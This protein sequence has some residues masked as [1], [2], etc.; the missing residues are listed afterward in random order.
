MTAFAIGPGELEVESLGP[1]KF[2]S[3]LPSARQRFVDDNDR[4]LFPSTTAE[5]ETLGSSSFR[6]AGARRNVFFEGSRS[7]CGIV[8]CGGLC[9]GI[10]NVIRAVVLTL[11]HGYG[12]R[13][14]LG[15]RY[16]Y[17]GVAGAV[18]AGPPM[19]LTPAEVEPIHRW[20]GTL[21]GSS[22]GPQDVGRMVDRLLE[23]KIDVLFTIGGDGTL[24]GAAALAAEIA[25][26]GLQIAVIGVP[27][28]IDNDIS[29]IERSFG[30]ATA[31][32]EAAKVVAGAHAEALG[33]LGGIGLVKLM[34][35]HSGFIAAHA[36]LATS[37][38]NFCLVPEVKVKL[39]LFLDALAER[40][41]ER[42]HAVIVVA[43]GAGQELLQ[44]DTPEH[45]A[46]GNLKLEDIGLYLKQAIADGL[47]KRG[48]TFSIKYLDPSYSVRS[49]PANALDAE[50]CLAL[51]QHAAHAGMAGF[52]STMVGF[53]NQH[54][55]LLPIKA[56]V[57]RRKQLDPRG[58]VW[59]RV[60]EATGQSSLR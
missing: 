8:S 44:D 4:V 1:G 48:A 47:K 9:P 50:Y 3:P 11:W 39:D 10:N 6:R 53:W 2:A 55:T 21:L 49:Q 57:A 27:K 56:A 5:L 22:R 23:R 54:F 24:K 31:V 25:R 34:G 45:D 14:I 16:G 46:S 19:T 28:T 15:F 43:E 60:L 30:F 13:R 36:T 38:V 52:T 20:G 42:R 58:S 33:A 32:D 41:A 35:R 18:T 17:A 26:R 59:Q 51:G 12:V 40:L 37:D 7:S 29:L